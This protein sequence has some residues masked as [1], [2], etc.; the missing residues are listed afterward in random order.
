ML[1][2]AAAPAPV[3]LQTQT[4][5]DIAWKKH[6]CSVLKN[7]VAASDDFLPHY[8][9]LSLLFSK[10]CTKLASELPDCLISVA[11]PARPISGS[12]CRA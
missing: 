6:V 5:C 1:A 12:H 11:G 4:I 9:H 3:P 2:E 8:V 10:S 7:V